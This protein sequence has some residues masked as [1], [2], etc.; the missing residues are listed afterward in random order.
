MKPTNRPIPASQKAAATE[1][2]RP[3]LRSVS[4]SAAGHRSDERLEQ[5]FAELAE[6][7]QA[8]KLSKD[9]WNGARREIAEL[10]ET[11]ARL[12]QRAVEQEQEVARTRLA[13]YH[14]ELTGLP[15]R[16]L[17]LDRLTQ[18]LSRAKRQRK[19]LALLVLDLDGFKAVND[20]WGHAVGDKLLRHVAD[21]LRSSIRGGDTACRYGGDEF[22]LL[23]PDVGDKERAL[24]VAMKVHGLLARPYE[25]DGETMVIA[26]S[27]G[28]ALS[29]GA[30]PAG[31]ASAH[32]KLI[33][34]ADAAMYVAKTFDGPARSAP[35]IALAR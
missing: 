1:P 9:L 24:H 20:K 3:R 19:P 5:A 12:R 21:R 23:L 18:A 30:V 22:I 26:A 13:A 15:N 29:K 14:D 34:E 16:S 4:A 25:I 8:L 6:A 2:R 10:K 27:I 28:I 11:N 35:K 31:G 7:R 32:E 33:N 17:L